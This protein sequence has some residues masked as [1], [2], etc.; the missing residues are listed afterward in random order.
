[1][2]KNNLKM[3]YLGNFLDFLEFSLFSSLMPL[4]SKEILGNNGSIQTASLLYLLFFIGFVGRP[5]GA[6]LF[7]YIGDKYGRKKALVLTILGMSVATFSLSIIPTWTYSYLIIALIRFLQGIFT[8]GEYANATVHVIEENSSDKNF[9]S[10]ANLTAAGIFGA[11]AGQILGIIVVSE[12]MPLLNWRYA[13]IIVSFVSLIVALS[14]T[15]RSPEILNE[16]SPINNSTISFHYKG[17]CKG[18]ILAGLVNGVFYLA[19]TFLGTFSSLTGNEVF[20][21]PYFISLI[22]SFLFGGI[23]IF[24]SKLKYIEKSN[25][26]FVINYSL[27]GM[28]IFIYPMYLELS[29]GN[30]SLYSIFLIVGFIYFMQTITLIIVAVYPKQFPPECRVLFSGLAISLGN[31]LIGGSSPYISSK[32]IEYTENINSPALYFIILIIIA[33]LINNYFPFNREEGKDEL[34]TFTR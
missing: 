1:M 6:I 19:Y 22:S 17:I 11:S 3:V 23:L 7:G 9:K 15:F 2:S 8:G 25:S 12:A 21:K 32:F 27:I 33:L 34:N 30:I 5:F 4:M 31:S 13:F 18:I 10:A 16:K 29:Q 26:T 20:I 28:L 14:R 24:C